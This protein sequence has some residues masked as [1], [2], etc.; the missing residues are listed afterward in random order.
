MSAIPT[1]DGGGNNKELMM[2]VVDTISQINRKTVTEMSDC[3]IFRH[4]N[5]EFLMNATGKFTALPISLGTEAQGSRT[6][7]AGATCLRISGDSVAR[8]LGIGV[9][10]GTFFSEI[11]HSAS[12]VIY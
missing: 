1:L 12:A 6:T 11:A 5:C 4:D 7:L 9:P 8:K 3:P 2:P 10:S